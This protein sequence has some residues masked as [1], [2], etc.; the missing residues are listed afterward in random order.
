M[1]LA[2]GAG[3]AL[4]RGRPTRP[5]PAARRA[6]VAFIVY[7]EVYYYMTPRSFLDCFNVIS[8]CLNVEILRNV[9]FLYLPNCIT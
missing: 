4:R 2:R 6:G 9:Y 8:I 5:A 7:L 3:T 1:W